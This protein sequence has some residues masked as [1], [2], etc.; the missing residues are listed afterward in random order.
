MS[1][2]SVSS[3]ILA[4]FLADFLYYLRASPCRYFGQGGIPGFGLGS[5]WFAGSGLYVP[6]ISFRAVGFGFRPVGISIPVIHEQSG[7]NLS[8]PDTESW[9]IMES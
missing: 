9:T 6:W 5:A 3:P 8:M 4:S 7:T 2:S 1:S